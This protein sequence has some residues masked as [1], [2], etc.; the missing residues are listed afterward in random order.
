MKTKQAD[1]GRR[2]LRRYSAEDRE[3]YLKEYKAS[4]QSRREFCE[5]H[6]INLT[7]F[8]GW[9]KPLKGAK[10]G[11]FVEM[12]VPVLHRAPIEVRFTNGVRVEIHPHGAPSE[13]IALIRGI[14][15]C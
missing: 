14:A 9:F 15:G 6:G 7:T 5:A 13:T 4:G 10:T 12:K 3:R 2:V 11:A 1:Q 8:H